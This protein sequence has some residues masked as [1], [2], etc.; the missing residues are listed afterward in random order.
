MR[1]KKMKLDGKVA[2]VTGAG[3]GLGKASAIEM[4][5]EGASL[6]IL[7][8]TPLELRETAGR[9]TDLGGEILSLRADVS[10]TKDVEKVVHQ[11]L[12][13]FG[14]IDILMNNAAIIGPLKPTFK[15][16][17]REWIRALDIN[18]KGVYLFSKAVIPHMIKQRWGKIINVISGLGEI[19][20]PPFGA[21]SVAKAG[22][23]HLTRF[24][25][26]ELK[27]YHIQANGLDP[28]IMDTRM[29]EEIRASGPEV[30]GIDLYQQVLGWKK[31][32]ELK[33]PE[34]VA[35]LAVFLASA[36]SD[37]FTGECGTETYYRK[38]GYR[39]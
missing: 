32:G 30:L 14:K 33:P 36:A 4:A 10:K 31:R 11:T 28:G 8:R 25:A 23:I 27:D 13:R 37:S 5:R 24:V 16:K 29:Q 9:I 35:R 15:I 22:L 17:E 3:R 26:E 2:I 34:R 38:R 19:V 18:L 12:T 20:M 6:V 21:Y 1:P 7:S 39:G